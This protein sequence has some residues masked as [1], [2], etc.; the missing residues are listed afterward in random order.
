M[1]VLKSAAWYALTD[2]ELDEILSCSELPVLEAYLETL[3]RAAMRLWKVKMPIEAKD[4][5]QTQVFHPASA[6]EDIQ[7]HLG[8]TMTQRLFDMYDSF[9]ILHI[10]HILHF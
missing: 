9:H 8:M 1:A 5:F 2:K 7:K 3:F 6:T 10:L 4:V